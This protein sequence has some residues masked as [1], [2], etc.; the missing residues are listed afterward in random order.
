M[1]EIHSNFH[2]TMTIKAKCIVFEQALLL[3]FKFCFSCHLPTSYVVMFVWTKLMCE[4][5]GVETI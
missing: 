5:C 4:S 3:L 2:V 1:K